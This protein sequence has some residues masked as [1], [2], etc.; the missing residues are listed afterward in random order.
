LLR[1]PPYRYH[2]PESVDEA[3]ALLSQLGSEALPIA[4][5]TDLIPNIKH[6]LFEPAHLVALRGLREL[7]GIR[8]TEGCLEIGAAETLTSV[9]GHPSVRRFFPSLA[10]AAGHVAGPQLRNAGTLGGNLC[11]DT[12]CTYYN[13]THFWRQALGFCLKKD[14]DV[15]HVT[16]VGKKCVA[17]HSADT[18]PV[19][20]TL[21]ARAEVVG[22]SG[23]RQVKVSDFFRADGIHN[24]RLG[25]GELVTRVRIPLPPAGT[26]TGYAKLRQ[27]KSID[28]P[29]LTVAAAARTDPDGRVIEL[30]GVVT[31]LG[32][33]PKELSG[34]LEAVEG[35][36]MNESLIE[37]LAE[38][39]HAQCH[40]LENITVDPEWRR[41]MVPVYVRRAL[42]AMFA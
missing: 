14:G 12:R 21:D 41:A 34:W 6:R 24:T 5:G 18:P 36:R 22:P 4:G 38:R 10:E 17:A 7:R 42:R 2:R 11:L 37:A 1:L 40:P 15:C 35:E 20:M 26:R 28:F 19:L 8:E 31:A 29:L 27:R 3:V 33:R 25:P 39:A 23:E 16:R 32:A 13:Q 30:K 9:A